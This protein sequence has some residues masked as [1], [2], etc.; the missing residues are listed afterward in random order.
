MHSLIYNIFYPQ[1][2]FSQNI[3]QPHPLPLPPLSRLLWKEVS[4]TG[5]SYSSNHHLLECCLNGDF[6]MVR[7][8][9]EEVGGSC[10]YQGRVRVGGKG[11]GKG[12]GEGEEGWEEVS[13]LEAAERGGNEKVVGYIRHGVGVE[14][15]EKKKGRKKGRAKNERGSIVNPDVLYGFTS[16]GVGDSVAKD[17]VFFYL[18]F[19]FFFFFLFL[20][21]FFF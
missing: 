17:L 1:N 12:E 15:E 6:G 3:S 18:F 10:S 8:L 7:F 5:P 14:R 19:F 21:I 16:S 4:A 9:V 20:M 13:C 11:K 2:H